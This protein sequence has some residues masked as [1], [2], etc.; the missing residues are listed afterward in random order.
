MSRS[1]IPTP[2]LPPL[3]TVDAPFLISA[4]ELRER[5]IKRRRKQTARLVALKPPV[6][7]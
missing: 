6:D 2:V 1:K 4:A 3:P 7:F 5:K